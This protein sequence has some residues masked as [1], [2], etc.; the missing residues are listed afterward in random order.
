MGPGESR[1]VGQGHL[2]GDIPT[3]T[4]LTA[5]LVKVQ[6]HG[7]IKNSPSTASFGEEVFL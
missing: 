3:H 1:V 2:R 7:E 6:I 5:V 4:V